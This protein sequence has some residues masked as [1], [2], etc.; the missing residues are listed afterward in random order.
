MLKTVKNV[1]KR[2]YWL[3]IKQSAAIDKTFPDN[4]RSSK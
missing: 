1:A 3:I 4:N 2:V